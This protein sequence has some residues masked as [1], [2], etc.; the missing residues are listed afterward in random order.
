MRK[1]K[2]SE[3]VEEMEGH[4]MKVEKIRREGGS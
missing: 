4:N 3:V 2:K 1:Y